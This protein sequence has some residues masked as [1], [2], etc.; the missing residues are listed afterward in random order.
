VIEQILRVLVEA[1]ADPL[2]A[3][4]AADVLDRGGSVEEALSALYA[5]PVPARDLAAELLVAA[6]LRAR[7]RVEVP[8]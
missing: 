3:V 7:D 6:S 4:R 8:R 2:A 5:A 1:G